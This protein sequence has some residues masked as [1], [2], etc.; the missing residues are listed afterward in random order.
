MAGTLFYYTVKIWL[1]DREKSI[2]LKSYS[3]NSS[4]V[5]YGDFLRYSDIFQV[6][7]NR[8]SAICHLLLKEYGGIIRFTE[9]SFTSNSCSGTPSL[10][11]PSRDQA[12]PSP[13]GLLN[14]EAQQAK[15]ALLCI[16]F[17]DTLDL[18]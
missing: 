14:G 16:F 1:S 2:I 10:S 7:A 18:E 6:K 11:F 17:K 5:V 3:L 4:T 12:P 15:I 9:F 13:R 8:L